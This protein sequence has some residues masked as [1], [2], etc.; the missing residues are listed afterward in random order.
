MKLRVSHHYG[1]ACLLSGVLLMSYPARA[2]ETEPQPAITVSPNIG[3]VSDYRFRGISLS[4]RDPAVQGGV[5]VTTRMG[6]F[7]G[8]WASSIAEYGGTNVEVDVYGGYQANAAG[9]DYT[10]TGYA[11]LYPGGSGVNYLELQGS[12]SHAVGTATVSVEADYAPDQKNTNVDNLYLGA[13]VEMP[14]PGTP[15]TAKLRGGRE[16]GFYNDKWDW[17]AG[18]SY[19]HDWLTASAPYV[20]TNHSGADEAGKLA[21]AGLVAS[22]IATF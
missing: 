19:A 17:E 6:L 7:A 4:D 20:D 1:V 16:N 11:Y 12:V 2:E 8:A 18:I 3:V 13:S 10:F 21:K 22:L 9:F 14:V 15:L 5:D